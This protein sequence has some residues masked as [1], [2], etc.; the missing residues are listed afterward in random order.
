MEGGG[1]QNVPFERGIVFKLS[2][3]LKVKHRLMFLHVHPEESAQVVV[4]PVDHG[5]PV[6]PHDWDLP[7]V[8]RFVLEQNVSVA[9]AEINRVEN[10]F[11]SKSV[12][13]AHAR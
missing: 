4:R 8:C 3:E 9:T 12:G 11:S 10:R 2:S 5:L 6:P 1:I 7:H 13:I